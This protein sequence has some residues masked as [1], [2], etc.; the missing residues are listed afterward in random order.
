MHRQWNWRVNCE[1][2][3]DEE[4]VQMAR[5]KIFNVRRENVTLQGVRTSH[6]RRKGAEVAMLIDKKWTRKADGHT[7]CGT[8]CAGPGE[9]AAQRRRIAPSACATAFAYSM[10]GVE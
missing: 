10:P 4:N 5:R 2:D 6:L 7:A 8:E 1:Y 3:Q 9:Q